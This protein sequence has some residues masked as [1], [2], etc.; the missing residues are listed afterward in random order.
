M[1]YLL[2]DPPPLSTHITDN[3]KVSV[4]Y[5]K[6]FTNVNGAISATVVPVPFQSTVTGTVSQG[7]VLQSPTYVATSEVNSITPPD[8]VL[9]YDA[10]TN[11]LKARIGGVWKE[12]TTS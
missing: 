7:A 6:Y 5:K 11:T 4:P 8:G 2:L 3:E 9:V 10:E 1:S 12:V